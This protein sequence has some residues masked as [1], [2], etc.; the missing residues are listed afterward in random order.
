MQ[1]R[2]K[3]TNTSHGITGT[4]KNIFAD[5][6]IWHIAN[7]WDPILTIVLRDSVP[8]NLRIINSCPSSN[9]HWP[10]RKNNIKEASWECRHNGGEGMHWKSPL[11]SSNVYTASL[12]DHIVCTRH[13]RG[14]SQ[15]KVAQLTVNITGTR[16]K[17]IRKPAQL[18]H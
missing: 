13:C 8:R 10:K 18:C 9:Y 7:V 5:C 17:Y 15:W 16:V 14:C 6:L 2:F 3:S 1:T 4:W 11:K 12:T